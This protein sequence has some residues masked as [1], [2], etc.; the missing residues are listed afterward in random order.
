MGCPHCRS[1]ATSK[2][3]HRTALGSR[4]FSCGSCHRRFN[5]RTGTPFNDLQFPTAIVLLALALVALLAPGEQRLILDRASERPPLPS[6]RVDSVSDQIA[7]Q[8][9]QR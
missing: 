5:E 9:Q 1:T 4:R 3:M 6:V 8:I 7:G 2:R